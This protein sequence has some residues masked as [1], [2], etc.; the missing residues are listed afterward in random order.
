[1]LTARGMNSDGENQHVCW[2]YIDVKKVELGFKA[3]I[4]KQRVMGQE[5]G[6]TR[7]TDN[8]HTNYWRE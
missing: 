4:T 2:D 3:K 7:I 5:I 1:M 8:P 6:P